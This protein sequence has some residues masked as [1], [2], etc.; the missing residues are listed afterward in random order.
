MITPMTNA[1]A[2]IYRMTQEIKQLK[3][4]NAELLEAL[5]EANAETV[6]YP[7][8][9]GRYAALIAKAQEV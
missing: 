8:H 5:K 9:P 3:Q 4:T 6:L 2:A 7:G 1:A